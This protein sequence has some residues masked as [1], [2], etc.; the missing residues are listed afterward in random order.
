MM[1]A[2]RKQTEGVGNVWSN[3]LSYLNAGGEGV[4][5]VSYAETSGITKD[6]QLTA[7]GK[8]YLKYYMGQQSRLMQK[9][10]T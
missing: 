1:K 7:K 10:L 9:I 5:D 3:V 8:A 2:Y 6:G 4:D